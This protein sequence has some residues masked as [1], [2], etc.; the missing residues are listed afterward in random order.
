MAGSPRNMTR[1]PPSPRGKNI[2]TDIVPY[3]RAWPRIKCSG[4]KSGRAKAL[5]ALPLTPALMLVKS[6]VQQ[7]QDFLCFGV[8][9]FDM[10]RPRQ[11]G[12]EQQS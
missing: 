12:F 8:Y 3:A 2:V 5:P 1:K 7:A 10:P 9:S 4:L 6:T 11:V